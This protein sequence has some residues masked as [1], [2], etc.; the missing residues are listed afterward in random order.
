MFKTSDLSLS[1]DRRKDGIDQCHLGDMSQVQIRR[2]QMRVRAASSSCDMGSDVCGE[3][4]VCCIVVRMVADIEG[5]EG[6][7]CAVL[8]SQK[9]ACVQ[10]MWLEPARRGPAFA[11]AV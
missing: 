1:L 2:G 4:G 3:V 6:R 5:V 10:H 7:E 8:C 9:A 11:C